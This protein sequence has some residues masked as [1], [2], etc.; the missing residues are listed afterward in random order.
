[1]WTIPTP[2]RSIKRPLAIPIWRV[3]WAGLGVGF[4]W[5]VLAYAMEAVSPLPS[6]DYGLWMNA[7]ALVMG[8]SFA[9]SLLWAWWAFKSA[10]DSSSANISVPQAAAVM[11][12]NQLLALALS[13]QVGHTLHDPLYA[14]FTHQVEGFDVAELRALPPDTWSVGPRLLVSGD[15]G[16]GSAEQVQTWLEKNPGVRT[17]ELSISNGLNLEALRLAALVSAQQLDTVARQEC[18]A[19]CSI[20]FLSGARRTASAQTVFLLHRTTVKVWSFLGQGSALDEAL[21]DLIAQRTRDTAL[22]DVYQETMPWAP[23]ILKGSELAKTWF[24]T[25]LTR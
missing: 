19:L 9:W 4:A 22:V 12:T 11:V 18:S 17:V 15:L 21:A 25:D 20:V 5:L 3:T 14:W 13:L 7:A 23:L 1:M 6:H 24:V 16:K 2:A 8:M 10:S